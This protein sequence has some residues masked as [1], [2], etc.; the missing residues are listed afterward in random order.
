MLKVD[1]RTVLAGF[2]ALPFANSTAFSQTGAQTSF[3]LGFLMPLTGGSGKLGQ[4]ML[5]GAQLAVEEINSAGKRKIDLIPEDSQALAKNGID[6]FGL[7]GCLR[8][9][10]AARD[11][12]Q[13]L[14]SVCQLC[15]ARAAVGFAILPIELDV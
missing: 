10:C 6:G 12:L 5:E 7:D 4:M 2:G 3:K 11:R 13:S 9:D 8:R 15:I 1:R 14:C